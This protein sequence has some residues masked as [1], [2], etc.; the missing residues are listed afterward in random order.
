M[1]SKRTSYLILIV[2]A[3]AW[4][5]LLFIPPLVAALEAPSTQ[6]SQ[7]AYRF[8][9]RICHQ[10]PSRSLH[11]FGHPLA[12]CA[13]CSAIYFGF[14]GGFFVAS[15]RSGS[16]PKRITAWLTFVLLPMFI[17]VVL[18]GI[19]IHASNMFTR[20]STGLIFGIGSGIILAPVFT[21][22]A[23]FV[24]SKLSFPDNHV[25]LFRKHEHAKAG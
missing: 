1:D 20:I 23:G 7:L 22:A 17:D 9:S 13:R 21:D 15:F 19:G 4:C 11:V 2:L 14:L 18:D 24:V 6:L 3:I 10:Y 12:V 16:E 5:S 25:R 8:F